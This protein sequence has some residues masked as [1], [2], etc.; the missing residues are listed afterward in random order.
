MS[1]SDDDS[2]IDR[3]EDVSIALHAMSIYIVVWRVGPL[4]NY[5]VLNFVNILW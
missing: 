2:G 5:V 4:H 3:Q 1:E